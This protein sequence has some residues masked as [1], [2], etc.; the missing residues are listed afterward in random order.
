MLITYDST[1]VVV[2]MKK[3]EH[4]SIVHMYS[5]KTYDKIFEEKFGS[6]E[7][8][9]CIKMNEIEQNSTGNKF[10][11]TYMDD[12]VFYV[13]TFGLQTRTQEEIEA[14]ELN[15]NEVFGIN[16]F[17]MAITD[18]PDPFINCCFINDGLLFVNFFYTFS[19]IHYHFLWDF[20]N[21]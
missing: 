17:S 4:M 8:G 10:A 14:E 1:R 7:C 11:A 15:I 19:Q 20:K 3:S 5:L 21:R 16:N 2:V 18:F 6:E 9:P 13:R 12:G